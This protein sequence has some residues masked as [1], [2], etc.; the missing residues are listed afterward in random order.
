MVG[1][2]QFWGISLGV[3]GTLFTGLGLGMLGYSVPYEYFSWNLVVFVVA[4]GLL[5]SQDILRVVARFGFRFVALGILVTAVG[6]VLT[7]LLGNL[8]SASGV[9]PLMVAGSYTGALTSSPGL[10][11]ALE[12][13]GGHHFVTIG[14]TIAYP[15]GVIAVVLFVHLAPA[16]FRLN[17]DRERKA[18]KESFNAGGRAGEG[19][20]SSRSFALLSFVVCMAVGVVFGSIPIPIPGVGVVSLGTTGGAL[21]IALLFGA[22]ERVGPLRM[23]M[24]RATLSA[25]RSF[26][27]AFF[28][29]VVGLMAGPELVEAFGQNGAAIMAI[30][31]FAAI[32]AMLAGFLVGRYV[33]RINWILLAGA[34]C[35]AMTSTPGLGAAIDATGEEECGAGYGATYPVAILCMVIFT[36]IIAE[37][38]I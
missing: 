22:M 28:L 23:R 25:F 16:I 36:K 33:F 19:D 20:G 11:A 6:A 1:R 7:V 10:G 24:D 21:I 5:A 4:V 15:F 29:A 37:G 35:G 12:A 8:F 17:L 32:G 31:F 38:R 9:H 14:Y 3:S 30:G 2:I 27:L 26:S 18:F 34:L 13:T